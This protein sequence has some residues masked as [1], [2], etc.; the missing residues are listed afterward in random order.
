MLSRIK[1]IGE[2]EQ[3]DDVGILAKKEAELSSL[4]AEEKI[5]SETEKLIAQKE[6]EGQTI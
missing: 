5:I 2:H 6:N 1:N 4:E 3:E